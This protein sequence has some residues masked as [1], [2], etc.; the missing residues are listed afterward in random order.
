MSHLSRLKSALLALQIFVAPRCSLGQMAIVHDLKAVGDYYVPLEHVCDGY[1]E[2]WDNCPDLEKCGPCEPKDCIL[3]SWSEWQLQGGCTGLKLRHREVEVQHNHCGQPCKGY[4]TETDKY[5]QDEHCKPKGKD[6]KFGAWGQWTVCQHKKD[7]SMRKRIIAQQPEE[8]GA[9]CKGALEETRPCGGPADTDCHVGEW[10][11]WTSCSAVCGK[12]RHTR[13]R[14]VNAEAHHGGKTCNLDLLETAECE[15]TNCE[16]SSDCELT[17]WSEWTQCDEMYVQTYRRR[18]VIKEPEGKGK[19]CN[20]SLKETLGCTPLEASDCEL[21]DWRPWSA[22]TASCNGGQ[23][24]RDRNVLK[25]PRR[26]GTCPN[27]QLR[28]TNGC[29]TAS[30][31][32]S[33]PQDCELGEWAAWSDCS[34]SCGEGSRV[35]SRKVAQLA[36]DGGQPCEGSLQEVK[37]CK[38]E[39]CQV[40]DCRWS[41]WERWST[42]SVTCGGGTKTRSRNI[43]VSPVGGAPCMPH[44]K[45]E[46]A[47]CGEE[48]CGGACQHGEWGQWREW[49]DCSSTCGEAYRFRRRNIAVHANYCGNATV[50]LRE[51]M[52]K[53]EDLPS[54]TQDVDCQTSEWAE[55][56]AC[57][58]HCFGMRSRSRYISRF[59][60]G[61]GAVCF[62][63]T[64][65][66]IEPCNPGPHEVRPADCSNI[67]QLDCKLNEWE[68]WSHCTVSCGGG[69]RNRVR[70]VKQSA[71][72]GGIPCVDSL[73]ETSGCNT[74]HCAAHRCQDC[75]WGPW[76]VWGQCPTCGG[77][78][79]RHRTIDIMPNYCG[80]RCDLQSSKEV[81]DCPASPL[82]SE[83]LFC[84]WNE[85]SVPRCDGTCGETAVM[86]TRTLGLHR[87]RPVDGAMFEVNSSMKCAGA[88][89]NQTECPFTHPCQ[90]CIPIPCTFS[91]WSDWQQPTCEGLCT[92]SRVVQNVNNECGE[93]CN[94]PLEATKRCAADCLSPRDCKMTEWSS[95]SACSDP[96]QANGQKYRE[97]SII[98]GPRNDGQPCLG[99]LEDTMGCKQ[100]LPQPCVFSEW[101]DWTACTASCGNGWTSRSRQIQSHAHRGGET[102]H[103]NMREM[104][105]CKGTGA[106]CEAGGAVDCLLGDWGMWSTCDVNKMMYRDKRVLRAAENQGQPCA[107]E[108]T[109]GQSCG[110]DPVDCRMSAW[111]GWG[112]CDRTCGEGQTRRQRQ[113]ELFAQFGGQEC[114]PELMETR[115][116]MQKACPTW[117]AEVSDWTPWSSCSFTCGPGQEKRERKILK[118]RSSGGRGFEGFL[119]EAR[120]CHGAQECP[121]QDC[122][123]NQWEQWTPCSC[124]CGGGQQERKRFVLHMPESGGD[125]CEPSDKIEMRACNTQSCGHSC[126]DGL[127]G[128]WGYWSEC[129]ASCDG[130]TTYRTRHIVQNASDCG[131]PAH[132]RA[133][134]TGIC[135]FKS[136]SESRD[137]VV[138]PWTEWGSCSSS[139]NGIM[140]RERSV[141]SYGKGS[142]LWCEGALKQVE[143]C[144][145]KPGEVPSEA[146][147][148]GDPVDCVQSDWTPWSMCSVTCG[149]GEHLRTRKILRHPKYGGKSCDGALAELKECARH[150]C[151][152]PAP[153]DCKYSSWNQWG[154]CDK[155]N[156]ERSRV[157]NIDNFPSNGGEECDPKATME[158]GKCP[159]RCGGQKFCE[160]TVWGTWSDCTV[161]CGKGGKRRRRRHLELTEQARNELPDYVSNVAKKFE[162]LRA[163]AQEL[164]SHQMSEMVASFVA[165][166]S[167]VTIILLGLRAWPRRPNQP[168]VAELA[169]RPIEEA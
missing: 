84:A 51:E 7:Q 165:G 99:A 141:E 134:E 124:S 17:Q 45:V 144:N 122:V 33:G 37:V 29:G 48:N 121:R 167:F 103:G 13:M 5:D 38:I 156:G 87:N 115:G 159:R 149:G 104:K 117:D 35:R 153:I 64:L 108:T 25:P 30:C 6:C 28:E 137:C 93:P 56:T 20:A 23:R 112:P 123:W 120:P 67:R 114:P 109:Q 42:C 133:H 71:M 19:L 4:L 43:A 89:V 147:E 160:W 41:D 73:L 65:K 100:T 152:G 39:D 54:C 90:D 8:G 106:A 62:N 105:K 18:E 151:G 21:S 126:Q 119:G 86:I 11:E 138:S 166:C 75:V 70:T 82:C 26:G 95:W 49:T 22:C 168:R 53:C 63:E 143:A 52:E 148:G 14:Y 74:Q 79:Y 157:R 58:C 155:C 91:P 164:Q 83:R 15:I 66:E 72:G 32:S 69:Q 57:S 68:D 60:S 12:G 2:Q 77:Q 76:S 169:Y 135:N 150:A 50:G 92:R 102:C 116:C 101:E 47:P 154:D 110:L 163:H 40:I 146:C 162:T 142:G 132:G 140:K 9:D 1:Q 27:V 136:C 80:K 46:V 107:G 85:W 158:I 161:T 16:A 113:I 44:H 96:G 129:S 31:S 24:F 34:S 3:G 125:R 36:I 10:H 97:R 139:C 81:S 61:S 88:Q 94:G 59:P 145:P 130:G 127:W 55:W 98:H 111:T 118:E 128:P 131:C 78:K